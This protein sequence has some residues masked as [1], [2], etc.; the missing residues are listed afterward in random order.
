MSLASEKDEPR[1]QKTRL[2]RSVL[3]S[4]QSE[5]ILRSSACFLGAPGGPV[6]FGSGHDLTVRAP[7]QTLC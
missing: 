5:H 1:S 2:L 7:H 6:G 3:L 4:A